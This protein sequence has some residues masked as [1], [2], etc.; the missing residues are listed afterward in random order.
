VSSGGGGTGYGINQNVGLVITRS[1]G[2]NPIISAVATVTA[3]GTGAIT[4]SSAFNITENGLG[5]GDDTTTTV[6]SSQVAQFNVIVGEG[7]AAGKIIDI[8]VSRQGIGYAEGELTLTI[9][10]SDSDNTPT[11]AAVAKVTVPST[12]IIDVGSIGSDNIIN[13]GAG[14]TA[15]VTAAF[16]VSVN[17]GYAATFD[18]TLNT[19]I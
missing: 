8:I 11:V 10:D 7:D 16:S 15:D 17:P 3:D 1:D 5:Y 18:V 12:G 14:Y 6:I 13:Q 19:Y 9:T 2:I 4:N